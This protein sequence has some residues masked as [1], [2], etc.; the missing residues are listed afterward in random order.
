MSFENARI[1][2]TGA[3]DRE[4]HADQ[5]AERGSPQFVMSVSA[6]REFARCPSRWQNGYVPPESDAKVDGSLFDCLLLTPQFFEARYAIRPATYENDKGETKPWNA[7]ANACKA[8]LEEHEDF[9]I[10][11]EDAVAECKKAI[12]RLR[13]D[14]ILAA[15]LDCCDTQVWI[16]ADWKDKPTGLSIPFKVLLD[17]VPNPEKET[18]ISFAGALGDLKRS[19]NANHEAWTRWA[20]F[21]GYHIQAAAY[22]DVFNATLKDD[23]RRR[24]TFHFILSE[25]YEPYEPGRRILAQDFMDLGRASYRT[26]LGNYAQCVKAQRFPGY[27]DTEDSALYNGWSLVVP[28]PWHAVNEQFAQRYQFTPSAEEPEPEFPS[29]T[30]T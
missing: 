3:D 21:A 14:E 5:K 11:T 25:N 4:Y 10:T 19:R 29:E 12:A 8:W 18:T 20:Y 7:N 15:W 23:E 1:V 30:P 17:F 26:M 16:E 9:K 2:K 24:D 28:S 22:T 13:S 27:D 6:L